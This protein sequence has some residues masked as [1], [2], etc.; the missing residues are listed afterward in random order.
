[1]SQ[2]AERLIPLPYLFDASIGYWTGEPDWDLLAEIL[3]GSVEAG[4]GPVSAAEWIAALRPGAAPATLQVSGVL[5]TVEGAD[6]ILRGEEA[7]V[8]RLAD[9]LEEDLRRA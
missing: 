6:L 8:E 4:L 1:M 7:E 9:R 3:A 5:L 2:P